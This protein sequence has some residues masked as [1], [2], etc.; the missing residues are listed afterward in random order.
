MK[1]I[2]KLIVFFALFSN[3]ISCPE[4][5][6]NLEI[7]LSHSPDSYI[8]LEYE[9]D[10][11]KVD[12][13]LRDAVN[14]Q[15]YQDW[16]ERNTSLFQIL[17]Y[18]T[19]ESVRNI[20]RLPRA[21][22]DSQPKQQIFETL[23]K[24]GDVL[25]GEEE[26]SES[27][28]LDKK[29]DEAI[30]NDAQKTNWFLT[31]LD[32]LGLESKDYAGMNAKLKEKYPNKT[33][34]QLADILIKQSSWLTAGVGFA[35][36]L[37]KMI[38]GM[39]TA[40]TMAVGL[41]G[42]MTDMVVLF[43]QQAILIFRIADLYGM[44]LT[45]ESRKTEALILFGVASGVTA[46]KRALKAALE[47]GVNLFVRKQITG[48]VVKD[49]VTDAATLHPLLKDVLAP[50]LSGRFASREVMENIAHGLIPLFGA[51]LS[52][53]MNYVFTKKVG[54][55]AKVFYA[56]DY[57]RITIN[58]QNAKNPKAEL[59]MFRAMVMMANADEDQKAEELLAIRKFLEQFK[60][61]GDMVNKML[62][63]DEKELEL[64]D[65]DISGLGVSLKREILHAVLTVQ[66]LD[67]E[68]SAVEQELAEK[69]AENLKL[70]PKD[71]AKISKKI[72]KKKSISENKLKQFIDKAYHQYRKF[73][74]AAN[75]QK[76]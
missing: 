68:A 28:G 18:C 44:D 36:D 31:V 48:K 32:K 13:L 7:N 52:G 25:S 63:G 74:G 2:G 33:K 14:A 10:V 43:R 21:P 30:E 54:H 60:Q 1:I 51:T 8:E 41:S 9:S 56:D 17:R 71:A 24:E 29:L 27:E 69:I 5:I 38:P 46:A 75:E 49:Q 39:G 58:L 64:H 62:Q 6:Q 57:E 72:Q 67:M 55:I 35:A 66:L 26:T 45:D 16:G 37:P 76:F 19:I 65:Y 3:L 50:F 20:R 53:T 34:S 70:S 11:P 59:A 47:G 40:H 61:N 23:Y 4:N 42:S 12:D 22:E 15:K 73:I